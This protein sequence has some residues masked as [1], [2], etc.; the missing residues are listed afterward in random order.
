MIRLSLLLMLISGIVLPTASAQ[1]APGDTPQLTLR[2]G[3]GNEAPPAGGPYDSS[4]VFSGSSGL[5]F[6][7][8]IAY[9]AE[10]QN[11]FDVPWGLLVSTAQT[12]FPTNLVPPPLF[13]QPPFVFVVP[14]PA[15]LDGGGLGSQPMSIPNGLY[16]GN[17]YLQAI[18]QDVSSFPAL[19]LSNGVRV[20]VT[21]PQFNARFSFVRSAPALGILDI[22]GVGH[23]DI[24]GDTLN[25]HP[26][27]AAGV[28]PLSDVDPVGLPAGMRFLPILSNTPDA[29][30]NPLSQPVTT[31]TASITTSPTENTFKVAD[32][33][34]FPERGS[35][36]VAFQGKHPWGKATSVGAPPKAEVV[37]YRGKTATSF[38]NVKR[39]R[40]GSSGNQPNNG[41]THNP[42]D[43]VVGEFSI[44]TTSAALSR[45]RI[46]LDARNPDLVHVVI[47][48]FSFQPAE[49]GTS[50]ALDLDLY[51]YEDQ[52]TKVQGFCLLDRSTHT[53]RVIP[54]TE[55]DGSS[56]DREWN[57]MVSIAPDGR[58]MIAAV[59]VDSGDFAVSPSFVDGSDPDELWAIRLDG[60]L[61]PVSGQETWN[62][63]Y[64]LGADASATDTDVRSR[65][66]SMPSVAIVGDDFQN[67]VAF[68]GLAHKFAQSDQGTNFSQ[69]S[70]NGPFNGFESRWVRR[71]VWVRDYIDVPLADPSAIGQAPVMPRPY[72]NADFGTTGSGLNVK[73]FDP[74]P[75]VAEDG[76]S[77]AMAGGPED[78]DEDMFFIDNITLSPT[79]EPVMAIRN[80]S[81]HGAGAGAS[82]G[83]MRLFYPGGQGQGN[84]A[85]MSPEGTYVAWAFQEASFDNRDW[86]HIA[87]TNGTGFATVD[88]VY[89]ILS[90]SKKFKIP[91]DFV[92]NRV[93]AGLHFVDEDR[94]AFLM[95]LTLYA[96]P[97]GFL[98]PLKI[99]QY[100]V[101]LYT[102]S[103]DIMVNLTNTAQS[104]SGLDTLGTIIPAGQFLS[105]SRRFLYI[106]RDGEPIQGN[107]I[108]A[109]GV[110]VM[111]I[112]GIDLVN[113][114]SFDVSGDELSVLGSLP[115]LDLPGGE[116][117][118]PIETLSTMGFV[119]GSGVQGSMMFFTS[120][121][122]GDLTETDQL[123]GF[124]MD[125]PFLGVSITGE[126]GAGTHISNVTPDPF[127]SR[128][129]FAQTADS[130]PL[131]N[132]QHAF[133]SDLATF[134]FIRDLTPALV[135]NGNIIGRVMDGS[136]HFLPPSSTQ[137]PAQW[138]AEGAL[139][140]SI[141]NMVDPVTGVATQTA[142][143]Y[144][145]LANLANTLL[146]PVPVLLPLLST[147]ELGPNYRIYLPSVGLS[148]GEP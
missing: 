81:G 116:A 121:I 112:L 133:V 13:V 57:P 95:G 65:L 69:D 114:G 14:T 5:F 101:F 64:Q 145:P 103:T 82:Q 90:P 98:N 34:G 91:G 83:S 139:V 134:S 117:L 125:A 6:S 148:T 141:G 47:P 18:V 86:L 27:F 55:V 25:T 85:A 107:T 42:G 26:P 80:L 59:K 147:E 22:E 10:N 97:M 78:V 77:V 92:G 62:I 9:L 144:Y 100:D 108:L 54:G 4:G 120:H 126:S 61:W 143:V 88:G 94:I 58:S 29:P 127:G 84:K 89:S 46:S 73:R 131:G 60:E 128:V 136:F 45:S 50:V 56:G 146:E 3:L 79:G 1:L 68:V 96:D 24:D 118:A 11:N 123:F 30:I 138:D 33:T 38:L 53:W 122:A 142:A 12:P 39:R 102:I 17:F 115:N 66:I 93:I 16:S 74:T 21:P 32:T 52:T 71:E 35:L 7:A 51:L 113:G 37:S 8:D 63:D 49:E 137:V 130:D 87:P 40:L 110:Q 99:P 2:D 28:A 44:V 76:R 19:K 31:I 109:P 106:V 105:P 23:R 20:D 72:I 124:D 111:N 15:M 135:L 43:F 132:T 36:L 41:F 75:I 140:F 67:L 129:A 119:E 48:Q 70:A 104:V